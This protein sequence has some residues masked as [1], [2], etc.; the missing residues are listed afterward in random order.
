MPV[1]PDNDC[2]P[3]L[4]DNHTQHSLYRFLSHKYIKKT[5][6]LYDINSNFNWISSLLDLRM[7]FFFVPV[8][9]KCNGLSATVW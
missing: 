3:V 9:D 6:N 4:P 5:E 2:V 1:L 7:F 8:T